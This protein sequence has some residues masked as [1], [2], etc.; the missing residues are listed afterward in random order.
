[1]EIVELHFVHIRATAWL[2][3]CPD[4]Y[5]DLLSRCTQTQDIRGQKYMEIVEMHFVHIR[6]TAW[7]VKCPDQ[8]N[9]LLSRSP[10]TQDIRNQ[11]YMELVLIFSFTFEQRRGKSNVLL[12]RSPQ[13]QDIRGHMELVNMH[14]IHIRTTAWKVKCP[15]IQIYPNS[16]HPRP[17]VHGVS[18]YAFRTHSN[19]CVESQCCPEQCN[20]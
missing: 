20:E 19:N 8:Y 3:E 9:G 17:E 1:M 10:Q 14:C 5:N 15:S 11:K 16:G 13:T 7:L 6:A 4:Q 2:V 18:R 12:S